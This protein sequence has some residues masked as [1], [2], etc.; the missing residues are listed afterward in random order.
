MTERKKITTVLLLICL[1]TA[2]YF[3]FGRSF[4][5]LLINNI[6]NQ[7]D[8][9]SYI[10]TSDIEVQNQKYLESFDAMPNNESTL[11]VGILLTTNQHIAN[12]LS[13]YDLKNSAQLALDEVNSN[14]MVGRRIEIIY[15]NDANDIRIARIAFENLTQ[16]G[17]KNIIVL[18]WKTFMNLA[19]LATE[20]NV[21]LFLATTSQFEY[22]SGY[23]TFRLR[24]FTVAPS[25]TMAD[26]VYNKMNLSE[27]TILYS[28]YPNDKR[29]LLLKDIFKWRFSDLGGV[30][31]NEISF[32]YWSNFDLQMAEID[33]A[34]PENI[35]IAVIGGRSVNEIIY[36]VEKIRERGI[37]SRIIL[38]IDI[39]NTSIRT[40]QSKLHVKENVVFLS[41]ET[42][43][44][45]EY[46][47]FLSAYQLIYGKPKNIWYLNEIY[48]GINIIAKTMKTCGGDDINCMK[49][50]F[51][52][53]RYQTTYGEMIFDDNGIPFREY[54]IKT[55]ENG[56]CVNLYTHSLLFTNISK[57]SELIR[58][59]KNVFN[60]PN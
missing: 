46:E 50:E 27:I 28:E 52:T 19:P 18:S 49:T 31:K 30:V 41:Y 21:L 14:E 17:V 43:I 44:E 5:G 53:N 39:C 15:Q 34:R 1:L 51:H 57:Y 23:N 60:V 3:Y 37:N 4:T 48:D 10:N 22:D 16:R 32:Q 35:L 7:T 8:N 2:T 54:N 56:E 55:I 38:P 40:L 12:F 26:V 9:Q 59:V 47:K 42:P 33:I 58:N 25:L 36:I 20:K 29:G 11:K 24:D 45:N 13:D 6:E